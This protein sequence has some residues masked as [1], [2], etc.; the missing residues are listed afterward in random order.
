MTYLPKNNKSY[1]VT[2][3]DETLLP[4]EQ[5]MDAQIQERI[6]NSSRMSKR[7]RDICEHSTE[8]HLEELKR[9]RNF[10]TQ[11]KERLQNAGLIYS[12]EWYEIMKELN[13]LDN[14]LFRRHYK[15]K[16]IVRE[17]L[18]PEFEGLIDYGKIYVPEN[19]YPGV[20]EALWSIYRAGIYD[21]LAANSQ[22][23][24][25]SEEIAKDFLKGVLPPM[26]MFY[27]RF[28]GVPYRNADRTINKKRPVTDK[29]SEFVLAHPEINVGISS[30]VENTPAAYE[31][32]FKA[33]FNSVLLE[34]E[35]CM[36]GSLLPCK[37]IV[38]AANQMI[39]YR[40]NNTKQSL[41]IKGLVK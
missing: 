33:G 30:S 18:D 21:V 22:T 32:A 37:A 7:V 16:D 4:G 14:F 12:T 25:P 20:K 2:D 36:Q 9:T 15:C 39:T 35:R 27:V 11:N 31:K 19:L 41:D 28:H 24:S 8:K 23:N 38:A 34:D 26:E 17:E 10:L 3:I 29:W 6:A 1:F 13:H 40:Y 5:L